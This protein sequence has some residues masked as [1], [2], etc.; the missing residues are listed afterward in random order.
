MNKERGKTKRNIKGLFSK[1]GSQ[2]YKNE[3]RRH[4]NVN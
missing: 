2:G 4:Y 3:V 1:E